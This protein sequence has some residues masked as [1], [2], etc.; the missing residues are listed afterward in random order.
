M[1]GLQLCLSV[2]AL[3]LLPSACGGGNPEP[4][5]SPPAASPSASPS[6]ASISPESSKGPEGSQT[7]GS[8]VEGFEGVESFPMKFVVPEGFSSPSEDGGTRGYA[9]DGTSGSAAAFLIRSLTQVEAADL[10]ADLA[11]HIQKTRDDLIVS[12][13]RATR[14]GGLPAQAFRL[15]QRFGTAPFDLW[16]ARAGSCFKP[17]AYKPMDVTAVRTGRGLVFFEVEY[18]PEDREKVQEPMQEWLESVRWE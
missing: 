11:G 12:D 16:C 13:I 9:I 18:L 1:T 15:K 8:P 7:P 4:D 10:P 3:L 5:S 14:V 6:A 2:G 17:L